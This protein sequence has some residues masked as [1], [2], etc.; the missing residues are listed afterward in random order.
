MG[1]FSPHSP[2]PII[3]I[4]NILK[5]SQTVV[6]YTINHIN[7]QNQCDYKTGKNLYLS[8]CFIY[9]FDKYTTSELNENA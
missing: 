4:C 5:I 7:F 1:M 6:K 9:K 8:L 3:T 2:P